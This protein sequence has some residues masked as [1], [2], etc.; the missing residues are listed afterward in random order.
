VRVVLRTAA[1]L[2]LRFGTEV[3]GGSVP[4]L[5]GNRVVRKGARVGRTFTV[6]ITTRDGQSVTRR[7]KLRPAGPHPGRVRR[8]ASRACTSCSLSR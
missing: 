6:R 1:P 8:T 5:A 2:P 4:T 7:L 3:K